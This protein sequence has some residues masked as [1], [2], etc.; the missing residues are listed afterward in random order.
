MSDTGCRGDGRR[1]GSGRHGRVVRNRGGDR[2]RARQ[3]GLALRAPC[4]PGRAPGADRRPRSGAS[5][6]LCDVSDRAQVDEVAARILERHPAIALLVNNAGIP[7][8]GSYLD[9]DP[10]RIERVIAVNYLGG[11]WC[12]RAFEPGLR[13]AAATVSP[14]RER[15]LRLRHRRVRAGRRVLGG[16]ARAARLLPIDRRAPDAGGAS[17]CTRCSRDSS[18]PRASRS[19]RP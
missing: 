14:R 2:A 16:E 19:A 17:R 7:A 3:R 10:E 9:I 12:L 5:S 6:R 15:R 8:R 1:A 13:A 18:R 11:V 4:P